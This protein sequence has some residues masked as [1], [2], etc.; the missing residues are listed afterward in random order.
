MYHE[1]VSK[2]NQGIIQHRKV[3]NKEVVHYANE[4]NPE[5]CLVRLYKLYQSRPPGR[6]NGA[7]YLKPLKNPKADVWFGYS[8]LGHNV[9]GNTIRRLFEHAEILGFMRT[10]LCV[11]QLAATRLF[12][13]GVDEQLIMKR[14]GHRSVG[15]VH[16]YKRVTDNL[17]MLTSCVLNEQ[18]PPAKKLKEEHEVVES[19]KAMPVVRTHSPFLTLLDP[20]ISLRTSICIR[21]CSFTL[22]C[23]FCLF[24]FVF[25]F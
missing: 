1:D 3:K 6:P 21:N 25:L 11:Q 2:T 19:E 18:V 17:N 8:P 7:F 16:S 23:F 24:S 22:P 10:I 14:T 13:A 9:L 4:G 12:D 20:R 5:S 15:G